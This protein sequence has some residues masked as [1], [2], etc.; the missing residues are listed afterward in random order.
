MRFQ[1]QRRKRLLWAVTLANALVCA[2]LILVVYAILAALGAFAAGVI[3]WPAFTLLTVGVFLSFIS[4]P[5]SK[6]S[7][8]RLQRRL[9]YTVN[10]SA[11]IVYLALIGSVATLWLHMTRR[12]FLVPA[13]FQGELY[14][15][16]ASTH[17][18]RGQS[19][20]LHTV[21]AF[22]GDGVLVTTDPFP[23]AFSDRYEYVYPDGHTRHIPDGP[24]GTL[25][26]T[27]KNRV[28]TTHAIA[29][30]PRDTGSGRCPIEEISIGTPAFLLSQHTEPLT[31]DEANPN[32][33]Q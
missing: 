19:G 6:A 8:G 10:G 24:F 22:P 2:L 18:T 25:P 15:V 3:L 4:W 21:Y 28:D 20:F 16:H 31:P 33:C 27:P 11:L 29:Y 9:G 14:V 32:I 13:G 1:A 17:G 7:P 23:S 26:D 12:L 5:L 30:F